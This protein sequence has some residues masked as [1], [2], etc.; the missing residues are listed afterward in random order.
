MKW[1]PKIIKMRINNKA[2]KT[3]MFTSMIRQQETSLIAGQS[4]I[5]A[6]KTARRFW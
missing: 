5:I 2:T 4:D 6:D 3:G 1:M